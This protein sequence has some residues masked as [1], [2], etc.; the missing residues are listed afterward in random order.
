[1]SNG[2]IISSRMSGAMEEYQHGA[3]SGWDNN[4]E[5]LTGRK[6]MSVGDFARAHVGQL[7]PMGVQ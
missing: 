2:A 3:M 7:N 5:K 4:V 1:V 6:P